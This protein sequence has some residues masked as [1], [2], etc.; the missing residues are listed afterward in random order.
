M[1]EKVKGTEAAAVVKGKEGKGKKTR[2]GTIL[3]AVMLC[4][5]LSMMAGGFIG[6]YMGKDEA[7]NGA[8]IRIRETKT[9]ETILRGSFAPGC[10]VFF[11]G[12]ELNVYED[13]GN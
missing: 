4:V 5:V 6:Y 12:Y 8:V 2:T 3:L 9:G 11:N 7:R 13:K 10:D 1:A